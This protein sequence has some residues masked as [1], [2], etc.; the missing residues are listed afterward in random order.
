M[1][2]EIPKS[3]LPNKINLSSLLLDA[4]HAPRPSIGKSAARA[5]AA[6]LN[7]KGSKARVRSTPLCNTELK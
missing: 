5:K 6:P 7:A 1:I 2:I 3:S 4:A